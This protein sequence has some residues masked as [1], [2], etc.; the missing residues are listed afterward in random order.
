MQ[1]GPPVFAVITATRSGE[2]KEQG[3]GTWPGSLVQKC[4]FDPQK[5]GWVFSHLEESSG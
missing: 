5:G 4:K 2:K 1:P 3:P